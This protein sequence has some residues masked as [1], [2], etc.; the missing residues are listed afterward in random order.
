LRVGGIFSLVT[1]IAAALTLA[2]GATTSSMSAQTTSGNVGLSSG[3]VVTSLQPKRGGVFGCPGDMDEVLFYTFEFILN[4]LVLLVILRT[5][6]FAAKLSRGTATAILAWITERRL[7][8]TFRP[9]QYF[10][11]TVLR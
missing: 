4:I 2:S 1:I 8:H 6:L 9:G 10:Q 11:S 5:L 3:T 7:M